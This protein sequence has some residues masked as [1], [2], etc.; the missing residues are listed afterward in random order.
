MSLTPIGRDV[1]MDADSFSYPL[2]HKILLGIMLSS[3]KEKDQTV[4]T[5]HTTCCWSNLI[6]CT[7]YSPRH[8]KIYVKHRAVLAYDSLF[9]E[10]SLCD[11]AYQVLLTLASSFWA[12]PPFFACIIVF[13]TVEHS[14]QLRLG[15]L[16]LVPVQRTGELDPLPCVGK[17]KGGTK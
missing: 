5:K 12:N 16:V 4:H 3:W 6:D 13:I 1:P 8:N 14:S 10:T 15:P 2:E 11:V 7:Q 17:G 9:A